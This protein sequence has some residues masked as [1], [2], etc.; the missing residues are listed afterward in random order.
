M[1][2]SKKK[3]LAIETLI[4]AG[5]RDIGGTGTGIYRGTTEK[6]K[7]AVK[8]AIELLYPDIFGREMSDNDRYNLHI[9]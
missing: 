9:L 8:W 1:T 3:K 5:A 2:L 7:I 4:Y 6:H